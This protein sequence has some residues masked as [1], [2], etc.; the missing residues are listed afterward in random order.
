VPSTD[1][2]QQLQQQINDG[3]AALH[4]D[5]QWTALLNLS[6]RMG[7]RYSTGNTLLIGLQRP[8]ATCVAGYEAWRKAGRQVRRG[9]HGIYILAPLVRRRAADTGTTDATADAGGPGEDADGHTGVFGFKNV[10]VFDISQTDGPDIPAATA[11]DGYTPEGLRDALTARITA[12]GYRVCYGDCRPAFGVTC[13]SD[14]TVTI[15]PGQPPAQDTLTVAHELGHL[16]CGHL[17]TDGRYVHRGTAE[18]EAE[19]V[20]YI[21]TTAAGMDTAGASFDY[22]GTWANGD[23]ALI[24]ATA[25]TVIRTARGLLHELDLNTAPAELA[26]AAA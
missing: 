4:Q 26:A 18:V 24:R 25:D 5:K 3:I 14:H 9:E 20:A 8:D 1:K 11:I 6:A 15:L 17:D 7:S 21:L 13:R 23:Q 22:I 2:A 19:S 10:A 12:F 16:A